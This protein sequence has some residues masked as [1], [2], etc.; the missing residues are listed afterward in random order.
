M[1]QH[2]TLLRAFRVVAA[3]YLMCAAAQLG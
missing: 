2:E 3:L 1:L